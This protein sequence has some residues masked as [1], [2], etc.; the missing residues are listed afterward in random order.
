M[1]SQTFM[2]FEIFPET[3]L[4]Y[5]RSLDNKL[6]DARKRG[7][8]NDMDKVLTR[9][10]ECH[11]N[12]PRDSIVL[13]TATALFP[14][15]SLIHHFKGNKELFA[16][17]YLSVIGQVYTGKDFKK[18]EKYLVHVRSKK[19]FQG[20]DQV[21]VA[22]AGYCE[23]IYDNL[24]VSPADIAIKEFKEEIKKYSS[25]TPLFVQDIGK[26][27]ELIERPNATLDFPVHFMGKERIRNPLL[28]FV[29]YLDSELEKEYPT[30]TNLG[31]LDKVSQ[32]LD[33]PE[34][35][36]VAWVPYGKLSEFWNDVTKAN[37]VFSVSKEICENL[38]SYFNILSE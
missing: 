11:I 5:A 20:D 15:P 28:S 6:E 38:M 8:A 21:S 31:E 35:R 32:D 12:Y 26:G 23:Y 27:S 22:Y 29:N 36:G 19:T 10:V 1:R 30:V 25:C 18:P 9:V 7:Y 17:P 3:S 24:L 16:G 4:K 13:N 33:D 2:E 14:K 34:V 37:R